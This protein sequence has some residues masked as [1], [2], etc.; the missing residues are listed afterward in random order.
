MGDP[1][2]TSLHTVNLSSVSSRL[3][4]LSFHFNSHWMPLA[5][6]LFKGPTLQLNSVLC[7]FSGIS[8]NDE[9]LS[10][11]NPLFIVNSKTNVR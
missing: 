4:Y 11:Y 2:P 10:Q 6:S 7:I 8:V 9:I 5:V 1:H 3:G